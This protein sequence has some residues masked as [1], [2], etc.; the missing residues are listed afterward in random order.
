MFIE[1]PQLKPI[2]CASSGRR[3]PKNSFGPQAGDDLLADDTLIVTLDQSGFLRRLFGEKLQTRSRFGLASAGSC[4]W[5][6][7]A[8]SRI[9]PSSVALRCK[10]P[11]S[12]SVES[13]SSAKTTE[14]TKNHAKNQASSKNPIQ[15]PSKHRQPMGKPCRK[16]SKDPKTPIWKNKGVFFLE[17]NKLL[18]TQTSLDV[19]RS[20]QTGDSCKALDDLFFFFCEQLITYKGDLLAF[21]DFTAKGLFDFFG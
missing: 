2:H 12:Q 10:D 15:K 16:A 21:V 6:L 8:T 14:R 7:E 4:P 5:F 3:H 13:R 11:S 19:L 9:E 18:G 20:K 17:E 1:I